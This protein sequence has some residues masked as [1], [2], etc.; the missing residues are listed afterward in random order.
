[1][2]FAR[3]PHVRR[4]TPTL[5]RVSLIALR[6]DSTRK[7]NAKAGLILSAV[8]VAGLAVLAPSMGVRTAFLY[9]AGLLVPAVWIALVARSRSIFLDPTRRMIVVRWRSPIFGRRQAELPLERF[10]HV[11]S[12]HPYRSPPAIVVALVERSGDRELVVEGFSAQYKRRGFWS[13]LKLVEGDAAQQLRTTVSV[14]T[15]LPNVGY[16]G[17]C[18]GLSASE[19]AI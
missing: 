2:R 13:S 7:P 4:S 16:R 10:S 15:G 5:D 1:V 9:M 6:S 17:V 11:V 14:K 3:S 19:R 8:A 12:Y 18:A